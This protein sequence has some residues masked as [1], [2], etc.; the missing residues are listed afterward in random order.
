MAE[1]LAGFLPRQPVVHCAVQVIGDLRNLT[2]GDQ[3]A[4]GNQAAVARS[5]RR[6]EPEIPEQHVGRVLHKAWRDLSKLLSDARGP[7]LL[8][9][10]V[11]R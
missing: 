4:H 8:R 1:H 9:R 3:R 2:G 7:L 5:Q 6:P 10:L 11:E